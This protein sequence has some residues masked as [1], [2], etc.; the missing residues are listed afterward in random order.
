MAKLLIALVVLGVAYAVR[1]DCGLDS[2]RGKAAGKRYLSLCR[3]GNNYY[4]CSGSQLSFG[5][6]G[7]WNQ[8]VNG[9][10]SCGMC[11]DT[12]AGKPDGKY[13]S[14]RKKRPY[15][16]SCEGGQLYY[17]QCQPFQIFNSWTKTCEC[18]EGVCRSGDGWK[19]SFCRGRG[20]RVYCQDGYPRLYADCPADKPYVSCRNGHECIA[21][22]ENDWGMCC[23]HFHF[24]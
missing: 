14:Y 20:W 3:P 24:F 12:C 9:F 16:Y 19:D 10:G 21:T 22:C 6:C 18:F 11:A 1:A 23:G 13:Q 15:Y 2:C 5:R 17:Q 7:N 8:C 4:T